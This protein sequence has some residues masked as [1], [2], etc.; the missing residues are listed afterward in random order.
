ML[1]SDRVTGKLQRGRYT[2]PTVQ[3][4]DSVLARLVKLQHDTERL[5]QQ[6]ELLAAAVRSLRKEVDALGAA[7]GSA[8][9]TGPVR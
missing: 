2:V 4:R 5:R 8:P 9:G 7:E 1:K 6:S 3:S